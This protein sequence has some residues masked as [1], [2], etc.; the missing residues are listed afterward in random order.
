MLNDIISWNTMVMI[1]VSVLA[2]HAGIKI[3]NKL[4]ERT[5]KKKNSLF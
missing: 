1:V 3:I 2:T 4:F 5:T